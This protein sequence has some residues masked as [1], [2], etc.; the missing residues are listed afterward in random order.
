MRGPLGER[1]ERC[2][3]LGPRRE[4]RGAIHEL[5][6]D[7]PVRIFVRDQAVPVVPLVGPRAA[8]GSGRTAWSTTAGAGRTASGGTSRRAASSAEIDRVGHAEMAQ[9]V[10]DLEAARAAADDD[11]R[12]VAGRER[13][14][15][16]LRH[17]F[18]FRRRRA[19]AWSIRYMTRGWPTR[20]GSTAGPARTRQRSVSER[21]DVG[22][23]RLAEQD[24]HLAEEVAPGQRGP[25]LAV[26]PDR[27][28]CPRGSRRTRSRSGPGG[29]P[30]R[31]PGTSAPRRCGRP[32]R[33]VAS[34]GPRT[35]RILRSCRR[36]SSVP[37]MGRAA[38]G[39]AGV[40]R[41]RGFPLPAAF[42]H[43]IRR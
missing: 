25:F 39:W 16:Q 15:A 27:A 1:P 33:A 38:S 30:D 26:D 36:S 32:I 7:R 29:G 28:A 18:A 2:L 43:R 11:D 4:V 10:R 41:G 24:R 20:N 42:C 9:R 23:R 17:R 6:L 31:H 35:A 8:C 5:G 3:H 14:V 40:G 21:D 12:I 13:P 34:S 37:A 22:D 19:D